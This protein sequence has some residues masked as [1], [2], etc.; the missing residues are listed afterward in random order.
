MNLT[1][2]RALDMSVPFYFFYAGQDS[3]V[4]TSSSQIVLSDPSGDRQ[5]YL[6][7]FY[8]GAYDL[9]WNSSELTGF[10]QYYG[11]QSGLFWSATD[12]NIPGSVYYSYSAADDGPGLMD[13]ALRGADRITGSSSADVLTGGGGSDTV[14]GGAGNDTLIGGSGADVLAG[15]AGNDVYVLDNIGDVVAED[16]GAGADWVKSSVS[17]TLEPNVEKLSL[18]GSSAAV[19]VGNA[20][21]NLLA[22]NSASNTL[23]GKGGGDTLTGLGGADTFAFA[24]GGSLLSAMDRITDLVVG[25]DK[26]DGPS[27]VSAVSLKEFG[28]VSA[29]G[30]AEIGKV[31]SASAFGANQ[32]ATFTFGLGGNTRTFLALNDGAAGFS[33]AGD[34][35]VEITGYSGSLSKLSVF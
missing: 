11:G 8:Y 18:T 14:N 16:S 5:E 10:R 4:S 20:L 22:G 7:R 30:Q 19:A 24:L 12:L 23:N 28:G 29:L 26:I 17:H 1:A 35:V 32:A 15:G 13:Y 34:N 21:G 27:A 6:G 3:V 9:N 31:L 2:N 25:V 33:A